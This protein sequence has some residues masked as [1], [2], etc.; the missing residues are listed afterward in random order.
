M[1]DGH[2]SKIADVTGL[3]K[4]ILEDTSAVC[5]LDFSTA[6][7]INGNGNPYDSECE[8]RGGDPVADQSSH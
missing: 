1:N 6:D 5:A 7:L 8:L 4:R 2:E 3:K